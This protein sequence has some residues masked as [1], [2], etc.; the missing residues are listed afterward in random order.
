MTNGSVYTDMRGPLGVSTAAYEQ[1][2]FY[3]EFSHEEIEQ[4]RVAFGGDL[5]KAS[6]VYRKITNEILT[7]VSDE[8][9]EKPL[10]AFSVEDLIAAHAARVS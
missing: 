3:C 9:V 10:A 8:D 2:L 6:E 7:A 4:V 1:E 5:E